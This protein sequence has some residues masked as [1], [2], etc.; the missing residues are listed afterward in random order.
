MCTPKQQLVIFKAALVLVFKAAPS[1]AEP[2]RHLFP[3]FFLVGL[4][5]V[6]R[7]MEGLVHFFWFFV[8]FYRYVF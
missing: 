5:F 2:S 7:I 3:C 4:S 1:V 6:Y 8:D